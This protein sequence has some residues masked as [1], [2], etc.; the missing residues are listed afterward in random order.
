MH[1]KTVKDIDL[2]N[3]KVI[4][5]ADFNVPLKGSEI[6]DD[7][8]IKAALPT[9]KYILEQGGSSL[10]LMS[11]LGRP[12]GKVVPEMSLKPVAKKL[13]ELLGCNVT[14]APDCTGNEVK[15]LAAGLD[16]G[17]VLLLENLRFHS[18]ETENNA[19][20]A[21][22]LA[23]LADVY[24]NDAFGTAHRAHAS[25]EGI[26]RNLPA[27]SGFLIE[28]EIKFL[29]SVLVN[30]EKPFIAIIGG[31]KVSSKIAVLESLLSKV[32][33]LIIGGGMTFTFLKVKGHDIGKSLFEEDYMDTAKELIEKAEK[34]GVELLL[35]EDHFVGA[36]FSEH[37]KAEYV[38]GPDI[39]DGKIGMD[40]GSKTLKKV[41]SK[42]KEAKTIFWNGPLG[43][44]EFDEFAAGTLQVAKEVA[45]CDGTTI[46]GGGDSVAA[47]NKFGLAEKIDHVSTGGGASLEF[48][49]GKA[50][51]GINALLSK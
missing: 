27:V 37:A 10:I 45:S 49:E 32:S 22:E 39:P 35:P 2:K 8:R 47:V 31:A 23:G 1:K 5:R 13:S 38:D 28:K 29:G 24:V 34:S 12:K 4:M 20:F 21:K 30:P 3:K 18:E 19:G 40:I 36:E 48:I 16:A 7:T 33:T 41:L 51:P 9:I 44:T 15:K 14:M 17:N 26:A 43:V 11:H 46:V 50:L 25:T 42:L 6:T